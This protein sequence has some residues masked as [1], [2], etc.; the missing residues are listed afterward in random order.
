MRK[1]TYYIALTIDGFIAAPDGTADFYPIG[2][3][4]TQYLTTEY[5]ETLPTHI[6]R[7]LGFDD[8]ANRHFDTVLMGG[9][10]YRI[11][12]DEG[13]TSPYGHLRQYVFSRADSPSPDPDVEFVAT[14]PLA[15]VRELK[16]EDGGQGV[17][18]CGGGELAGLLLPEID[19]LVTKVYPVVAGGGIPMFAT[20]FAGPVPFALTDS[21]TF[22]NGAA[23]LTYERVRD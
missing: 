17:Y 22:G 10:T 21:R 7:M 15:R 16:A 18:L 8:A 11:A 20:D 1:L 14:D 19:E 3:D 12:L 4:M 2:E 9:A 23:V 6:R 13:N 5:P